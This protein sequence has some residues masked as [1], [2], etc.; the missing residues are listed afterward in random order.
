MVQLIWLM[1]PN[2]A[3]IG[4]YAEISTFVVKRQYFYAVLPHTKPHLTCY[5]PVNPDV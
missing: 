2:E 1:N 5:V 3:F 4:N